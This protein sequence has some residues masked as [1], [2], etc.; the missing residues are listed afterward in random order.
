MPIRATCPR[1]D[2]VIMATDEDDLVAKVQAHARDDHAFTR[3]L[4]RKH[5][6]AL[7]RRQGGHRGD[8]SR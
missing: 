3:A 6:L 8:H 4:P 5:I 1:C 7:L 2:A